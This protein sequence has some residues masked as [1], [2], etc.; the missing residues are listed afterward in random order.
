MGADN[1]WATCDAESPQVATRLA[2]V[3]KGGLSAMPAATTLTTLLVLFVDE[4]N[5][6]EH[7]VGCVECQ[8]RRVTEITNAVAKCS[9]DLR[10]WGQ[11]STS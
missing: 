4:T 9:R 8:R 3:R 1:R 11:I 5:I 2:T 7:F 6:I 10:K